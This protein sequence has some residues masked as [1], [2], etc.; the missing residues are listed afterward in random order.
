MCISRI[1]TAL[2]RYLS[3]CRTDRGVIARKY[4]MGEYSE[5]DE[6]MTHVPEGC[7][8]V[9]EWVKGNQM[10]RR[11]V[12]ELEEITPYIGNP[13]DPV[14]RRWTWIGDV[15]TDVD[16][17]AAVEKYLMPGNEIRLD[18]LLMFLNCHDDMEI[19]Y[20]DPASGEELLF[21]N[22]GVSINRYGPA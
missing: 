17:T 19:R 9:E 2:D 22:S 5:Y 15:S 8:Y 7:I 11:I 20:V 13:F 4:L 12:Y 3:S 18:L 16:I 6:D 14:R 1:L 21:P 10:R